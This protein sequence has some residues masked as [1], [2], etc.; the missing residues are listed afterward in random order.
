MAGTALASL[1]IGF[2]SLS[3]L[4]LVG[5]SRGFGVAGVVVAGLTCGT[6]VGIAVQGRLI[7]RFGL[8]TVLLSAVA[9]QVGAAGCLVV[10]VWASAPVGLM[11]LCAVPTGCGEPQVGAPMRALWTVLLPAEERDA[12]A[13]ISS[14]LLQ[15]SAVVGPLLL[16]GLLPFAGRG[17]SV[18]AAVGMFAIGTFLLVSSRPA[19]RWHPPVATGRRRVGALESAGVRVVTAIGAVQGGIGG[20]VQ[21]AAA[22]AG[23][24][25]GDEDI[26]LVLYAALATGSLV[27]TL[28]YGARTWRGAV[29]RRMVIQLGLASLALVAGSGSMVVV[30]RGGFAVALLTV[31]LVAVGLA[32]GPVGVTAYAV[33]ERVAPEGSMVAAFTTLTAAG[34]T[35]MA[36]GT[37][38][39]GVVCDQAGPA[40]TLL[41]A[42]GVGLIGITVLAVSGA[43]L[44]LDPSSHRGAR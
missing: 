9:V 25:S 13:A 30:D 28:W 10:S 14:L 38:A 16:A 11:L 36:L 39:A 22:A 5:H 27:G 7:D 12:A 44:R 40:V 21:V 15:L 42:S 23:A 1:P 19:R 32:T 31:S 43:G 41:L 17:G 29:D 26:A 2:L 37:A 35:S 18:L 33:V 6:G 8:T 24:T 3:V 4:L 34:L 20:L